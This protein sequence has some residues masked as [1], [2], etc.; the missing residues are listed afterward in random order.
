MNGPFGVGKTTTGR[1]LERRWPQAR[2]VDPERLGWALRRTVGRLVPGDYQDLAM[3]RSGTTSLAHRGQQRGS[4]VLVP[5]A[6]LRPEV[7]DRLLGGL[8]ARGDDVRVV[9][10]DASPE[11]LRARIGA[12]AVE[13]GARAWREG[14]VEAYVAA[15]SALA[16]RGHVVGTDGRSPREVAEAVANLVSASLRG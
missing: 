16:A 6:V 5:M 12:D 11:V 4:P 14:H 10:L 7:L 15:R 8:R 2:L 13:A 9:L 1:L 3:W